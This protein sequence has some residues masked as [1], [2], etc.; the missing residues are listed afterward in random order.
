MKIRYINESF[1]KISDLKK[2]AKAE[3]TND[4]FSKD[5]L[6]SIVDSV[7]SNEEFQKRCSGS[8]VKFIST[9]GFNNYDKFPGVMQ[10]TYTDEKDGTLYLNAEV[11]YRNDATEKESSLRRIYL[12]DEILKKTS[13]KKNP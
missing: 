11:Y 10:F 5:A 3:I 2:N 12:K 8:I 6:K 1:R 9:N 7:L 4:E 13:S